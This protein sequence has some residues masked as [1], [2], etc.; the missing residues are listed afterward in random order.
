MHKVISLQAGFPSSPAA[1]EVH[2]AQDHLSFLLLF[3]LHIHFKLYNSQG[4]FLDQREE[5]GLKG[6]NLS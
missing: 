1:A 3:L 2:Q 6:T 5:I 4:I